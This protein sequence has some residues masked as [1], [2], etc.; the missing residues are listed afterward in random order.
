[1]TNR[2]KTC[3]FIGIIAND[4][5]PVVFSG[6]SIAAQDSVI[7]ASRKWG[8]K[9]SLPPVR[10]PSTPTSRRG[11]PRRNIFPV[12]RRGPAIG[13]SENI[14]FDTRR[15]DDTF[16]AWMD[17]PLVVR[18]GW[19]APTPPRDNTYSVDQEFAYLGQG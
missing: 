8:V 19:R 5:D 14:R 3:L 13:L 15:Q 6:E 11:N 17:I 1:M 10:R 9:C 4:F 18:M 16:R 12:G 2:Y 7:L